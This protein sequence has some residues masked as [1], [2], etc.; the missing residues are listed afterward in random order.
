MCVMLLLRNSSGSSLTIQL[1]LVVS[2]T[3]NQEFCH[4]CKRLPVW[5]T[6]D[7]FIDWLNKVSNKIV[8]QKCKIW[9]SWTLG[10]LIQL[11]NSPVWNWHSSLPTPPHI[12]SHVMLGLSAYWK[13][14]TTVTYSYI[15]HHISDVADTNRPTKKV[16]VSVVQQSLWSVLLTMNS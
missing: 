5:M 7:L 1:N 6:P 9:S 3:W 2:K 8:L 10:L 15:L 4:R 12:Y 14:T 16:T 11:L 13:C